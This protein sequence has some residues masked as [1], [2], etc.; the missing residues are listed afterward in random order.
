MKQET[1]GENDPQRPPLT[2][3]SIANP[4]DRQVD[5]DALAEVRDSLEGRSLDREYLIENLH[6][7]QDLFGRLSTRHLA[8][9]ASEMTLPLS[10]VY[11]VAS[12]YH[13]FEIVQDSGNHQRP[14]VLRICDGIACEMAG[15]DQLIE[16]AKKVL[17]DKVRVLRAPCVGACHQAPAAML[18]Q[19]RIEQ[20]TAEILGDEVEKG[21]TDPII[22]DYRNLND[23]IG[24]GGYSMLRACRAGEKDREKVIG[25]I[26]EAG[27][28]GMGGA[29]FPTARKWRFL[30]GASGP[31][32][33]VINADEGEPGTFKDRHCL[34]TEPH[35][36]LEGV[37]ITAW[38]IQAEAVYIYL[39]DEYPEI[40]DLLK[41]EIEA[42]RSAGLA[43]G[44]EIHLRRGAGAYICGEE[45]ALL[46]SIEGKRGLPR[47]R[48]P[49]PAQRGLF[50]RP[51]IINNVE[52]M[53][54]VGEILT[55]G[56]EWYLN[57][58]QP[59][60][61]CVSGRVQ[62]PGVIRAP[63][64][65]TARQLIDE[66]CG[67]ISDGHVFKGFLPGGASGGILPASM[68]DLPL[69][70]GE[71]EEHGCFV[72]SGALVVLSDADD[73]RQ[74]V[75]NLLRFFASESCGQCTPCRIGSEK[76]LRLVEASDWDQGRI[77]DLIGVMRGASIC[78]LGQAAP[79][80]VAAAFRFFEDELE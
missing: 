55:H 50:G 31:R 48:P 24:D 23:H 53:F 34:E 67:G 76:M 35:K 11:E 12:F 22:P 72:G 66:H 5:D 42:V 54:W 79:N 68:A 32:V 13:H 21:G 44:M 2:A 17:G 3:G 69:K 6:A 46:E 8:A 61:Y 41:T 1:S 36:I 73:I 71:L 4:M 7:V 77:E 56:A 75:A 62:N 59:R 52:T 18:G 43:G 60:F 57:E 33:L 30:D 65:V 28:R 9:L 38:A 29:G 49:Y 51:T 26:E 16:D 78:G 39:R 64:G 47:N 19:R 40:R 25:E 74:V 20:A 15:A 10:D 58:G 27:L 80:P 14:P 63:S 45:S 70:F 37:L